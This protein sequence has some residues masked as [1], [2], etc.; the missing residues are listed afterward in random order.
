MDPWNCGVDSAPAPP[1]PLLYIEFVA[2][3]YL[4]SEYALNKSMPIV[5]LMPMP[6]SIVAEGLSVSVSPGISVSS[7]SI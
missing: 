6:A 2:I 3:R 5:E 4:Y 1:R 7:T